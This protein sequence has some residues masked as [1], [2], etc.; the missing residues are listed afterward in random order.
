MGY[1]SKSGRARTN[2][3]KP[4]AFKVC[5]RCGMWYNS[6]DLVWQYDYRGRGL[7]NLRILVCKRTCEDVSQPQLK[8]RIIPPDPVAIQ[9]ARTELFAQYETNTR[10]TQ[11]MVTDFFTGIP[12]ATGDVRITQNY[13]TRVTQQTGQPPGGRNLFPGVRFMVPGD[14]TDNVPYGCRVFQTV[15]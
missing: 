9:N 3:N 13:N 8:P 5:D 10:T 12:M 2:V 4:E 6:S 1:A 15:D 14:G 7:A 11:G